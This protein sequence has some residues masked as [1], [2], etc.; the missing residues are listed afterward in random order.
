MLLHTFNWYWEEFEL[1]A[2]QTF[3]INYSGPNPLKEMD[4][5]QSMIGTSIATTFEVIGRTFF[6]C[7]IN[8]FKIRDKLPTYTV[9][10]GWGP[11]NLDK[12]NPK[13]LE[14]YG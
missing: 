5:Y 4:K 2:K 9:A 10:S 12:D 13:K 8:P 3:L 7:C 14:N 6:F 1:K 11:N